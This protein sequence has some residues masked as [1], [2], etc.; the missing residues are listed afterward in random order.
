MVVYGCGCARARDVWVGVWVSDGVRVGVFVGGDVCVRQYMRER[1][2]VFGGGGGG[3]CAGACV[4]RVRVC[5][6]VS[7]RVSQCVYSMR[8]SFLVN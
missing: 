1:A 8:L 2:C 7:V 6:C 3:V 5:Q 4:R